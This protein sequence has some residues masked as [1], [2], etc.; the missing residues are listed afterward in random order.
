MEIKKNQYYFKDMDYYICETPKILLE[1]IDER[2]DIL[3]DAL[4]Q[5][6]E[7]QKE[8][9]LLGSGSSYTAAQ[10]VKYFLQKMTGK[11]VTLLYPNNVLH[12]EILN[13]S[14]AAVIGISQSG[15]SVAAIEAIKKLKKEG[16]PVIALTQDLNSDTAKNAD[17]V[18]ALSC[19]E[20]SCGPKTK[21]YSST[22]FLLMLLGLEY[23]LKENRISEA[24]Y[25]NVVLKPSEFQ[26]DMVASLA[27]RAEAVR[28]RQGQ[29][30]EDN[31]LKNWY[32]QNRERMI[33]VQKIACVGYG[34]NYGTAV[35]GSLKLIETVRCPA[36]GYEFEEYLHGPNDGIDRNST[37]F[38][39][40]SQDVELDRMRRFL[41][42]ANGITTECF[43][44]TSDFTGKQKNVVPIRFKDN[45]NFAPL[46]YVVVLQYL[47]YR[48]SKDRAVDLNIIK[49]PEYYTIMNC[50]TKI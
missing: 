49:Y 24:E 48:I 36:F 34:A 10:T 38:L 5:L 6:K 2:K 15:N 16:Y 33:A 29:P 8:L 23:A 50:K 7:E 32:E 43:M 28:D 21:G 41:D 20:E 25:E 40:G 46:E 13:N 18:I 19:H 4:V 31:M 35:E 9:I 12:Y 27:E 1:L 30:Y 42:F 14:S 37:I 22:V 26:K 39:L 17:A 11:I 44:F 3:K 45:G 47:A